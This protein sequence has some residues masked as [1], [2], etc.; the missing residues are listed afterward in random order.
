MG[1]A[2]AEQARCDVDQQLVDAAFAQQRAVQLV[3]GLDVEFIDR[4]SPSA[5]ITAGRSTLPALFGICHDFDAARA[6]RLGARREFAVVARAEDQR[7]WAFEQPCAARARRD[8]G[9]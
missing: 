2:C 3:A 6:Q 5:S 9:Q 4:R 7:R 1:I 8:C